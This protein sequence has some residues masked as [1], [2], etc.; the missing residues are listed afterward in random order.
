MQTQINQL[1]QQVEVEKREKELQSERAKKYEK[2]LSQFAKTG[3]SEIGNMFANMMRSKGAPQEQIDA[4][5]KWVANNGDS[6]VEV[7]G[8]MLVSACRTV[9]EATEH[10]DELSEIDYRLK[11]LDHVQK[12][13][14]TE[15][16]QHKPS[17]RVM[18]KGK[19]S[20]AD[21][22]KDEK[23]SVPDG[24]SGAGSGSRDADG[25]QKISAAVGAD[26]KESEYWEP[27]ASHGWRATEYGHP[28]HR[29]VLASVR[30]TAEKCKLEFKGGADMD[31]RQ[32]RTADG[33]SRGVSLLGSYLG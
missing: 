33:E 24:G 9:G 7:G 10:P 23:G 25:D 6:L 12:G 15:T 5:T 17:E 31:R 29:G 19:R 18:H 14:S 32:K 3:K 8:D 28:I 30:E 1:K 2:Q 21:S 11:L 22:S 27:P 26:G 13:G 20:G 4:I 16:F